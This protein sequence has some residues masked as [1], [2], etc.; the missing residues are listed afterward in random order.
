MEKLAFRNLEIYLL[1][2]KM[3]ENFCDGHCS[4]S[5]EGKHILTS[6]YKK[7]NVKELSRDMSQGKTS[8]VPILL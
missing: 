6:I 3:S 7:L 5:L 2:A 4:K 8:Y 1:A